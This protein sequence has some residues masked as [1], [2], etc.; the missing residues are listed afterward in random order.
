MSASSSKKVII[1]ALLGNLLISFCKFI[2]A[3]ITKSSAMLSEGIHSLVDSGNQI[4]LLYGIKQADKPADNLHPYGHGKEIYFWSLIVAISIFGIGA[5]V[6]IYEGIHHIIHP[7]KIT[8]PL[9]NYLIL[10]ISILF[11]GTVWC[12][13]LKEFSK[14]KG[15]LSYVNAVKESKDPTLFLVLFEDSAAL[16]GLLIALL[17][18]YLSKKTQNPFWDGA[19]SVIIGCILATTAWWL[20]YESKGLLIGE[21]AISQTTNDLKEYLSQF[22][23][24]T[25]LNEVITMHF[26]PKYILVNI[27]LDFENNLSALQVEEFTKNVTKEIK[28]KNDLIKKVFIEAKSK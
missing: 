14:Q 9:W 3:Y 17:G 11:E 1:A 18:I 5:G 2:G 16:L 25:K 6:S 19:A 23:E 12:L 21:S 24:V 15:K 8:E 4:L 22:S 7:V 13:A 10:G 26:G 27:S 28:L 20:A